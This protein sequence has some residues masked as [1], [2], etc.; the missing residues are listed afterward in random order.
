MD[1]TRDVLEGTYKIEDY[2]VSA[3]R[4]KIK[5][6]YLAYGLKKDIC[7]YERSPLCLSLDKGINTE[8]I[9]DMCVYICV[10]ICQQGLKAMISQ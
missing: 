8:I 3:K 6:L 4:K 7:K 10:Y 9:I 1:T 5:L 2:L